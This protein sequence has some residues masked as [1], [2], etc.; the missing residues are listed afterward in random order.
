VDVVRRPLTPIRVV[1]VRDGRRLE[2]PDV[3]ATEEPMEVRAHGPAQQPAAVAVTLRTPGHDFDLAVG[4][5]HGEGLLL[6]GEVA[7]VCYCEQVEKADQAYNIVTVVLRRRFV[8]PPVR[9]FTATAACGVCGKASLD[10]VAA[11]CDPVAPGP[12]VDAELLAR[13]PERLRAGQAVFERTGGL[14]GAGLF[15]ADGEVL[16][17]REDI[18]RHNA[19]DKVVG[20]ALLAGRLPLSGTILVVSGRLGFEIVQKAAMAGI[21]LVGAVSAPSSLAV[22]TADRLGVTLAGFMR[23]R[24]MNLYT[25]PERVP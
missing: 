4:F 20:W 22:A 24:S 21:G 5:L 1:A 7:M 14:H 8:P 23:G 18:G 3:L 2:K 11:R 6:P 16:C 10:E 19:V 17:L 25:H 12:V 13:L 9:A 15:T